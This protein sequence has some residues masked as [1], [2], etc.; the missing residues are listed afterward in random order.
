MDEEAVGTFFWRGLG[1]RN[2]DDIKETMLMPSTVCV[3]MDDS[4]ERVTKTK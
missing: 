1:A 4:S 2:R 3:T